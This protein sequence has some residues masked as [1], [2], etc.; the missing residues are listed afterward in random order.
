MGNMSRMAQ[1]LRSRIAIALA[2]AVL[3]GGVSAAVAVMPST[4]SRIN[5][6]LTTQPTATSTSGDLAGD[7][8]ATPEGTTTEGAT[9]TTPARPTPTRTPAPLGNQANPLRGS[10]VT[11]TT[12]SNSFTIS[13]GGRHFTIDVNPSTTYGGLAHSLAELQADLSTPTPGGTPT[14]RVLRASVIGSQSQA[15]ATTYLASHVFTSLDN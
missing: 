11:V 10:V 12:A 9:P 14:P 3:F 5:G 15:S 13:S 1:L 4:Y 7:E 2:G 8:T 6:L